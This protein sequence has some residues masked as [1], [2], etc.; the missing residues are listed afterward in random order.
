M[1]T[2]ATAFISMLIVVSVFLYTMVT[3][4]QKTPQRHPVTAAGHLLITECENG[5]Q[6]YMVFI[7][8]GADHERFQR[9]F[10]EAYKLQ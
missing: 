4:V 3:C 9:E 6:M 8:E 10:C 5:G 7:P 2:A 1:R